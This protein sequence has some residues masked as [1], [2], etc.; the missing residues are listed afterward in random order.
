VG[1]GQKTEEVEKRC[2]MITLP[3][4]VPDPIESQCDQAK[5]SRWLQRKAVAH[6]RRDR[7]RERSCT[8]AQYKKEIHEAVCQSGGKDFYTG[9]E[10]SWALVSTY[11]NLSS[12]DGRSIYKEKFANLP[13]IDHTVDDQ[14]HPRFVICSWRINEAKG[15]MRMDEFYQLCQSILDYRDQRKMALSGE[16]TTE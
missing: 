2:F 13:T 9:Q 16:S 15:D 11:D 8:V 5:Y 10:L 3:Y 7:K 1:Q 12:R 4:A 14:G 6:V